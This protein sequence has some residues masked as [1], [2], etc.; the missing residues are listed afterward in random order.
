MQCT[1]ESNQPR[2]WQGAGRHS[3]VVC[4][5]VIATALSATGPWA[6]R[7]QGVLVP[8]ALGSYLLSI[9]CSAHRHKLLLEDE[10][11]GLLRSFVILTVTLCPAGLTAPCLP[12][13]EQDSM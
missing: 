9:M 8:V 6:Q 10:I 2:G 4:C 1:G 13:Q 7:K 11:H 5:Y 3:F 12:F